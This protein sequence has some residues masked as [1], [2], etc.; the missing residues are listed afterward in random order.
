M[1]GKEVRAMKD[2]ELRLEIAKLRNSIYDVR[3]KRETEAVQDTAQPG[4][5]RKDIARLLTEQ[6]ARQI[7]ASPSPA[8]AEAKGAAPKKVA[9]KT[10]KAASK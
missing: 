5:V 9:R 1:N 2:D 3:A 4:K 7:K 8:R 10:V 6:R